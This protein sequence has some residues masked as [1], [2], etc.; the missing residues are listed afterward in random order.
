M[1]HGVHEVIKEES[2]STPIKTVFNSSASF[3]GHRFN[4]YWAKG[5]CVVNDMLG[6][7]LRF[8]ENYVAIAGGISKM[9]NTVHL[10]PTDQH[11]HRFV[12]RDLD[13]NKRIEHYI[14]IT[15]TFGDKPSGTIAVVALKN[16]AKL[17]QGIYPYE[18]KIIMDN[19]YVDDIL[20]FI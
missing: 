8:R 17:M 2:Q 15:V 7:F 1:R 18:C 9:Y 10:S 11:N 19:S 20:F 13:V 16:I 4:D 14:L 5:L 6:V 3:P 12:W